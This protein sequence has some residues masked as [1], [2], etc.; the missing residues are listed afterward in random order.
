MAQNRHCSFKAGQFG[1]T[2][3]EYRAPIWNPATPRSRFQD[4][5]WSLKYPLTEKAARSRG[6]L[7]DVDPE[8]AE[9]VQYPFKICPRKRFI[10][11]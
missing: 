1:T 3:A 10:V 2:V 7:H 9:Y 6:Y 5:R 8:R 4:G 11:C